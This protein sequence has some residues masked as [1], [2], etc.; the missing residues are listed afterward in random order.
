[1][2]TTSNQNV[3][4]VR[5]GYRKNAVKVLHIRREVIHHYITELIADIQLTLKTH[6]DYLTGD[7]SDI[8][9]TD[10]IK[11]TVHALATLKGFLFTIEGFAMDICKH[12]LTAFN[13]VTR[14]RVNTDEV[15]WKRLEKNGVEHT[16]ASIHCPEAW[17]FCE[18]EQH[19]SMTPVVHNGIKDMKVLKT[20]LSGF[21]SSYG[22]IFTTLKDAKDRFFCT[23]VYARWKTVKDTIIQKFAGPYDHGEYFPSVQKTLYERSSGIGLSNK[24]EGYNSFD[25]PSGNITGTVCR[26]PR[27]KM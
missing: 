27:A 10:T 5:T 18:V 22:T 13:H 24:D 14:G 21:E 23:S 3:E 1:M 2:A 17:Q 4:F 6:K 7:N 9:P 16:H 26:K 19:L 20:T 11:N 8:I 12:F 25:N 15:P